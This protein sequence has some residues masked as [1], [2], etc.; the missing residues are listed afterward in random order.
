MVFGAAAA[1][2]FLAACGGPAKPA[3]V[4]SADP[5]ASPSA[6]DGERSPVADEASAGVSDAQFAALLI[7]HW[8]WTM[9]SNPTWATTL[10][11][12]R[13]DDTLAVR[14]ARAI[15]AERAAI[16]AFLDRARTLDHESLDAADAIT[17]ELFTES[18]EAS[19][20]REVCE[21]HLWSV[22]PRTNHVTRFGA[23][24][25]RHE[26][27][28]PDDGDNLLSR[29]RMIPEVI[30]ADIEN[31][32]RGAE[33][34][35][36][37]S[38]EVLRRTIALI[39]G[40]LAQPVEDWAM[41]GPA[42]A[43]RPDW[44]EE[45]AKAFS[46][47]ILEALR[48]DVQPAFARYRALLAD[49]LLPAARGPEAEGLVALPQGEACYQALIRGFTA[50]PE[51]T[52][53]ELHQLGL[54]EVERINGEMRELGERLF[55]TRDLAAIIERL[56]TDEELYFGSEEEIVETAEQAVAKAREAMSEAFGILPQA[57]VV[58]VPI[59]DYEAPFTTIAYYR[60]PHAD[61]SKPG[62]YFI[63]T[64]EPET[65][66][67]FEAEVLAY[68]EAIPGHHLQ[69][70]IAQERS[71]LPAFRRYLG[72]TAFVEGWALYTERLSDEMEL[73]SGDLDRMG[74]LSYDAWR[75]NR[76]VVDTGI[77][78]QGWTRE[79]AEQF[80][81]E[82]TALTLGNIRNEVDRY[83]TMPGQAVA[84]KIGQ[85]EILRLRELAREAL[86]DAFTLADFHDEVLRRGA[87]TL[88]VLA[89]HIHAWLDR[90]P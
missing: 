22:S 50:L 18:L 76:L 68:H 62:E 40:V 32:R 77:H 86:G 30:D 24:S 59:P 71:E 36:L 12:R 11:D 19:V 48:D 49:E 13:F 55:G 72:N 5:A 7:D 1:V 10:G 74:M 61:G 28:T 6:A 3:D 87:I 17:F 8:D 4:P 63:N 51:L 83:I 29:Y 38:A 85:L 90:A 33:A 65:R 75:A 60:A 82:N 79:Q 27:R 80:M 52:A 64:Y 25:D 89:D 39:D 43:E 88:P 47:G 20:A 44:P 81:R 67:R 2:A 41:A 15:E 84:Y 66:P 56:R 58:V 35:R 57:D 14:D 23:L 37:A 73:Y 21:T 70:A 34:G 46:A 54:K 42:Q 78:A 9:R 69:I 26:V 31:L 53:E 45:R 16:R